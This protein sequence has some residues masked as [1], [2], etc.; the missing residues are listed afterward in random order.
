MPGNILQAQFQI[1]KMGYIV[2]VLIIF[3]NVFNVRFQKKVEKFIS[4]EES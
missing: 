3:E 1:E 2:S 4:L